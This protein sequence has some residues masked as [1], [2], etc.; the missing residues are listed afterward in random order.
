MVNGEPSVTQRF[1]NT[2]W[3]WDSTKAPRYGDV[4][5]FRDP[6]SNYI[7]RV[8]RGADIHHGFHR[9]AIRVHDARERGRRLRPVQVRVLVGARPGVEVGR[10]EYLHG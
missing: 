2:G 5:A 9:L 8:G 3:W 7:Y 6:K 1:G 4:A 10:P